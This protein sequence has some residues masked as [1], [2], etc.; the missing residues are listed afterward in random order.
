M[1]EVPTSNLSSELQEVRGVKVTIVSCGVG[2][3]PQVVR[4]DLP[5]EAK[6]AV[7]AAGRDIA[8][9]FALLPAR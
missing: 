4:Q 8:D 2:V 1:P 5:P 6:Q 7:I 3:I 9:R